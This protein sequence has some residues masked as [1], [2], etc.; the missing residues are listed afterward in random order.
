MF[1]PTMLNAWVQC[2]AHP[3]RTPDPRG[4]GCIHVYKWTSGGLELYRRWHQ[5][6]RA[7]GSQRALAVARDCIH[8]GAEASWWDWDEGSAL[9]FWRWPKACRQWAMQGQ[10]HFLTGD[11]PEFKV[12]QAPAKTE[13]K[14][15]RVME[16]VSKVRRRRYIAVGLVLS[17]THMFYVA[18]GLDDIRMV[19]NGTSCGLNDA[20]WSPHFGLPTV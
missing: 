2:R 14:G 4:G 6:Q 1:H 5:E 11:F 10:P 18:K 13:D 9:I 12:P 20:L 8:R 15:K 19:Y 17:L 3:A 7:H 16:K